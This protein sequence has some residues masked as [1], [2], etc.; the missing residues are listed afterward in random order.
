MSHRALWL[1]VVTAGIGLSFAAGLIVG[2]TGEDSAPAPVTGSP[3]STLDAAQVLSPQVLTG[4]DGTVYL[5]V[6]TGR[7]WTYDGRTYYPVDPAAAQ[8]TE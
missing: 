2:V 7:G 4:D 3:S 1:P 6:D 8:V 5:P